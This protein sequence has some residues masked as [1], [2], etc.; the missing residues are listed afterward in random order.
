MA[1]EIVR[2]LTKGDRLRS[3][4]ALL[5]DATG[6]AVDLTGYGVL[7]RM[8]G[9]TDGTVKVDNVAATIV[10]ASSGEVR[11][12]PTSSAVDT[13]GDFFAWFIR[14]QTTS[15]GMIEHFPAGRA[16]KIRIMPDT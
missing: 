1:N 3:P 15:T 4:R 2:I 13:A 9:A 6:E 11:Y 10:T 7:F 8:I 5:K 14:Y 16:L 12:T